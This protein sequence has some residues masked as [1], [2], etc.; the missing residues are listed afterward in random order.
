MLNE[1]N[2]ELKEYFVSWQALLSSRADAAFFAALK[3]VALGWKVADKAEYDRIYSMLH[4][5]CDTI[6]ETWMNGRW[7]AKMHLKDTVLQSGITI[8]KLMQRRP[9]ST[10]LIGLD[11]VDFYTPATDNGETVMGQE[12]NLTWTRESNDVLEDYNWLS[13]W[14]DD[15]EAK[16]KNATV[17]NNIIREL[18]LTNQQILN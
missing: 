12:P 2:S 5:K 7:I 16:I 18:E 10:D 4:D 1:I 14:F 13:I 11:H 8:I 3:P 9:D 15:T 6:V 17:L